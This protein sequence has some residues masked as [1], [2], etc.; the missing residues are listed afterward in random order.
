[1][2]KWSRKSALAASLCLASLSPR[3]EAAAPGGSLDDAEVN[4]KAPPTERRGGFAVGS[5]TVAS[6]VDVAGYPNEAAALGD[7][8]RLEATG[9]SFGYGSIFWLGGTIRDF[10]TVGAGIASATPLTSD[11]NGGAFGFVLHV[12]GFPLYALGRGFRD[13][14]VAIDGGP[15]VGALFAKDA[16][17]SDEP[18]AMGGGMSFV[19]VTTFYEPVRFWHFSL[20]PA[21]SITHTFSQTMTANQFGLGL[22]FVFYGDQP[23]EAPTSASG[24]RSLF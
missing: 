14:G 21:L 15:S 23:D 3:L 8:D 9:P 20:G 11:Y 22:R 12:E 2:W 7:P 4:Y 5:T 18:L 6:I 1:M 10:L 13:L 17:P 24:A 16:A 19:G